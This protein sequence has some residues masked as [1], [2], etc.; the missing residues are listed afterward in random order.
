MIIKLNTTATKYIGKLDFYSI[1]TDP[2]K[3][4]TISI[5]GNVTSV[6]KTDG[7]STTITGRV[8][9]AD[10]YTLDSVVIKMGGTPISGYDSDTGKFTIT[11]ITGNV[12]ITAK[13]ISESGSGEE[14]GDSDTLE[15]TLIETFAGQIDKT[16]VGTKISRGNTNLETHTSS[17]YL[18]PAGA[19]VTITV[20]QVASASSFAITNKEDTILEIVA[21]NNGPVDG[22]YTFKAYSEELYLYVS[23]KYLI[24]MTVQASN[25]V[26]L[27]PKAILTDGHVTQNNSVGNAIQFAGS[28]AGTKTNKYEIPAGAVVTLVHV[29]GGNYGFAMTDLNNIVT[30]YTKTD[31]AKTAT[32]QSTHVFKAPTQNSYLYLSAVKVVSVTMSIA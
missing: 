4:V 3:G 32:D 16:N 13:A 20:E 6:K 23:N 12:L 25:T 15:L 19:A 18:V 9:V 26:N 7:A 10:G 8:S 29:N 30:E 31:S 22:T 11:G 28:S 17:K 1:N 24:N 21:V 27:V 2:S 5:D 14:G